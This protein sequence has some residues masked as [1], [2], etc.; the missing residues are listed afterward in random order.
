MFAGTVSIGQD[1][2][3]AVLVELGRSAGRW[4]RRLMFV[5]G[6]QR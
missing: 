1:A 6:Y 5:N 2:L 4:M 3:H